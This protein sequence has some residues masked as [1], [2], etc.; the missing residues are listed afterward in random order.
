MGKWESQ[1]GTTISIYHSD[2]FL[3]NDAVEFF[4]MMRS[5]DLYKNSHI[6]R[7]VILVINELFLSAS[8]IF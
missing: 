3:I 8:I 7:E 6:D 5:G 1:P 4:K 2:G